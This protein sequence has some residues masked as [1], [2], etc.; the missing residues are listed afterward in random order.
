MY[1]FC[2]V[3]QLALQVEKDDHVCCYLETGTTSI[4][5]FY[6]VYVLEATLITV[7]KEFRLAGY[8]QGPG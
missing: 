6:V 7:F 8:I 1:I 2:T 3:C 5:M 4:P